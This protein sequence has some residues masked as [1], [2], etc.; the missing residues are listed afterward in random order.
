MTH[1]FSDAGLE[2]HADLHPIPLLVY[3]E[4]R[5]LQQLFS[6][7]LENATRYTDRG[8][9]LHA[10]VQRERGQ[11]MIVIEDSAPGVSDDN[12]GLRSEEH[13]SELQSLMRFPYAVF[14]LKKNIIAAY[15]C[16]RRYTTHDKK[17]PTHTQ[18]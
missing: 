8:G 18:K 4:E 6:N 16:I 14:C 7:L 15:K 2:M 9:A 12:H 10:S 13:T 3:G 5:R 1:R 17:C 11:A